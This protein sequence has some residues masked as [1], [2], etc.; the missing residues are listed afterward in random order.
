MKH[1]LAHLYTQEI[2][3]I[4]IIGIELIIAKEAGAVGELIEQM[5]GL[6]GIFTGTS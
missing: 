5:I 6:E 4:I 1:S 2:T 3:F